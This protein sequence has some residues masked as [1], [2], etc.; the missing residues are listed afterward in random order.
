MAKQEN[1]VIGWN[2]Q[3]I[4]IREMDNCDNSAISV[5][6]KIFFK[7]FGKW[8]MCYDCGRNMGT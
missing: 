4:I 5:L 8:L 7:Q 3:K 6:S 1:N 2:K